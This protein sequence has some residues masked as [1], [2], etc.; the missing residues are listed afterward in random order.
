MSS[1]LKHTYRINDAVGKIMHLL[2]F[3]ASEAAGELKSRKTFS[4]HYTK[5]EKLAD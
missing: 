1:S 3:F 4:Q 5:R 2:M